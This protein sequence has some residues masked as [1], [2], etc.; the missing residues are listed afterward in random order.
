MKSPGFCT[1]A[2]LCL[3]EIRIQLNCED[4]NPLQLF[5]LNVSESCIEKQ[6]LPEFE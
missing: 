1:V 4:L 5:T 6:I 2:K 3:S